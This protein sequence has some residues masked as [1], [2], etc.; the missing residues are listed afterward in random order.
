MKLIH[1]ADIHLDSP[2]RGL[3]R[4]GADNADLVRQATRRALENLVRLT[5]REEAQVLIIAGDLYDGDWNDFSTGQFFLKQMGALADSGVEVVMVTGNHDAAS[6]ITRSLR[7]PPHVKMLSTDAPE[8]HF[9]DDLGLAVHGQ[10]YANRSV[11]A[12]LAAAYPRP[13]QGLVNVGV[14]HTSAAGYDGHQTYAPCSKADLEGLGYH[15]MALGHVHN[16]QAVVEG[17]HPAWFSGNTQGRHARE[18][19]PKGAL[20][21]DVEVDEPAKV[22]FK[23]LDHVRWALLEVDAS[24]LESTDD[25]LDRV[26]D[27]IRSTVAEAGG[28]P[29][30]GRF[31]IHGSTPVASKFQ[32]DV[33]AHA[34]LERLAD[35]HHLI[36]EKLRFE[37]TAPPSPDPEADEVRA[38]VGRFAKEL[39]LDVD[40]LREIANGL[41][42]EIRELARGKTDGLVT[43]IDLHNAETLQQILRHALDGLDAQLAGGVL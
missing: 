38:A 14:L 27:K 12:N 18:T 3:D 8:S 4:I 33:W 15:Y 31:R 43:G 26:D 2:L 10:G 30:I 36:I 7:L 6:Q 32:D 17:D 16:R 22:T 13:T 19:G 23:E 29:V 5:L 40:A 34:E 25:V 1:A 28:R 21:V 9:L 39:E 37:V 42:R 11:Q 20:V 41:D 24:G 35:K